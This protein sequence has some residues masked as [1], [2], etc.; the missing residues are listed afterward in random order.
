MDENIKAVHLLSKARKALKKDNKRVTDDIARLK[1]DLEELN[2]EEK[3]SIN[4]WTKELKKYLKV[5]SK[6]QR[7]DDDRKENENEQR[8]L[9][10]G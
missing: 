5:V 6:H 8:K 1:G 7:Q 2:M 10:T 9:S 4:G 3:K